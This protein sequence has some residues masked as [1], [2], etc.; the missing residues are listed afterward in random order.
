MQRRQVRRCLLPVLQRSQCHVQRAVRVVDVGAR[1][2]GQRHHHRQRQRLQLRRA[3]VLMPVALHHRT[4]LELVAHTGNAQVVLLVIGQIEHRLAAGQHRLQRGQRGVGHGALARFAGG[5]AGLRM[6]ACVQ[7]GLAHQRDGAH[8]RARVGLHAAHLV[9]DVL[10]HARGD[11]L[12]FAVQ[13]R[14]GAIGRTQRQQRTLAAEDAA[15]RRR[16]H[17]GEAQ[18][19]R[20][21]HLIGLQVELLGH[22]LLGTHDRRTCRQPTR[23][24][25]PHFRARA[26]GRWQ[27]REGAEARPRGG[28]WPQ[29]GRHAHAAG[30][31]D[32]AGV[33][34]AA[35]QGPDTRT[36][37]HG[38]PGAGG[39]DEAVL[40]HQRAVLDHAARAQHQPRT[41]D[42]VPAWRV[43]AQALHA[44]AA[45][46]CP[47]SRCRHSG[48]PRQHPGQQRLP[49]FE[50]HH[51]KPLPRAATR[52]R[53]RTLNG[54][55][56]RARVARQALSVAARAAH[57][58]AGCR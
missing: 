35:G 44:L 9:R 11:D 49:G 3:P 15:A 50:L 53:R 54:G 52:G 58:P 32:E 42:G 21:A 20:A 27:R 22:R 1:R 23:H 38:Q 12:R 18:F 29:R 39:H 37:G 4:Q 57:A 30:E 31:V 36:G 14:V 25:R 41:G 47:G 56:A 43:V 40:H 55:R 48:Q 2:K 10:R 34:G 26:G 6:P 17:R 8:Q 5:A 16:E 45:G 24:Q 7:Q 19:T 46:L 13:R 28:R 33:D 51:L